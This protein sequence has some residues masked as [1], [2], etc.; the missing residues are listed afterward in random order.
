MPGM[1][2]IEDDYVWR[3]ED[4]VLADIASRSG[5]VVRNARNAFH[6][7]QLV[8]KPSSIWDPS[9]T[10]RVDAALL[11][12]QRKRVAETQYFGLVKYVPSDIQWARR[13]AS[14]F[15][16]ELWRRFDYPVSE[17]VRASRDGR[18]GWTV[19]LLKGV[20]WEFLRYY[21]RLVGRLIRP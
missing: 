3:Q 17:L 14:Q 21:A 16:I 10:V 4:F 7:H 9:I 12:E 2:S 1:A 20:P 13:E 6:Y 19:A 15:F 5:G 11:P 18:G 8:Y